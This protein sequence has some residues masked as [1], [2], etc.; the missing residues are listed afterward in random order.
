MPVEQGD[1]R[2]PTIG[3]G[4]QLIEIGC[5]VPRSGRL[6]VVAE[7]AVGAGHVDHVDV[8]TIFAGHVAGLQ[9]FLHHDARREQMNARAIVVIRFLPVIPQPVAAGQD[10]ASPRRRRVPH[11]LVDRPRGQPQ[12]QAL[13]VRAVRQLPQ[14]PAHDAFQ[15][16]GVGRLV[17][18]Q[19]RHAHADERRVNG[20]VRAAFTVQAQSRRRPREEEFRP[21]VG[22]RRSER[23]RPRA[24]KGSYTVPTGSRT[25]PLN[26]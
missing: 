6:E 14:P 1:R 20:L 10:L 2:G 7:Q 23:P 24:T 16:G 11:R 17:V 22:S 5:P 26:S 8:N 13:A 21:H 25:S 19:S 3:G 9:C 4:Q 12:V 15:L 18:D